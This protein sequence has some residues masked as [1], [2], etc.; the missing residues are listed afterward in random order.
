MKH[1]KKLGNSPKVDYA[2]IYKYIESCKTNSQV[3]ICEK[4]IARFKAT[5]PNEVYRA[6]RLYMFCSF[7]K[8]HNFHLYYKQPGEP[9]HSPRRK[10]RRSGKS[11]KDSSCSVIAGSITL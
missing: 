4:I 3:E 1:S 2:K 9:G 10:R 7:K 8:E 6:Y 5:Y 11:R